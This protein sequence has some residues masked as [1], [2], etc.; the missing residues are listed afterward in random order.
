[1]DVVPADKPVP[2]PILGQIYQ[3]SAQDLRKYGLPLVTFGQHGQGL[4]VHM[5]VTVL[6]VSPLKMVIWGQALVDLGIFES[7]VKSPPNAQGPNKRLI[8]RPAGRL[9]LAYANQ[10]M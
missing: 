7:C 6:T 8:V 1:M 5:T 4:T 10:I 3:P 9:W 2:Q